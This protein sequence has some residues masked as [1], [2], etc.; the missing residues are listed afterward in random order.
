MSQ[1]TFG[2]QV[3]KKKKSIYFWFLK[4]P[5]FIVITSVNSANFALPATVMYPISMTA[6]KKLIHRLRRKLKL[7]YVSQYGF[8]LE[9]KILGAFDK[10]IIEPLFSR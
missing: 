10:F 9:K 4:V 8:L 6:V 7:H 5:K 2:I 1:D 3:N